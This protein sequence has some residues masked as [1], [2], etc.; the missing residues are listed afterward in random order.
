M[1]L[2]Q[3]KR[4]SR[5]IC[6]RTGISRKIS[7][8]PP[9]PIFDLEVTREPLVQSLVTFNHCSSLIICLPPF[10]STHSRD[11]AFG[12]SSRLPSSSLLRL[13]AAVVITHRR[14][15]SLRR[16]PPCLIPLQPNT[17]LSVLLF[18]SL[19]RPCE[20][21]S[22]LISPASVTCVLL[23]LLLCRTI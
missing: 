22:S 11:S 7:I 2:S 19:S 9:S 18:S 15:S 16:P 1:S 4:T 8:D 5:L 20:R 17:V 23:L 3:L 14:R 12:S 13:V 6:G 10:A 21:P